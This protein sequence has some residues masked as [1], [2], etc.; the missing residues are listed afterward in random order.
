MLLI[1]KDTLN[2]LKARFDLENNI[3]IFPGAGD[4]EGKVLRE[5]RAGHLMVSL[6]LDS[7]WFVFMIR[8]F[9]RRLRDLVFSSNVMSEAC[10]VKR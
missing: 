8:L 4:L 1:G 7:S 3:R 10:S 9:H 6:L 5:S 2:F